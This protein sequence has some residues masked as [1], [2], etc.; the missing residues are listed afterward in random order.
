MPFL[1][2]LLLAGG[3]VG[4]GTALAAESSSLLYCCVEAN[5]QKACGDTLPQACLG[6]GH[7]VIDSRGI[8]VREVSPPLSAEQRAALAEEKRLQ[9]EQAARQKEQARRD[10]VILI[11]YGSEQEIDQMRERAEGE[12]QHAIRD[13]ERK[14][15]ETEQA[16]KDLNEQL[17]ADPND[18]DKDAPSSQDIN[19]KIRDLQA[20]YKLNQELL[21]AKRKELAS[22]RVQ[23]DDTKVRYREARSRADR[24]ASSSTASSGNGK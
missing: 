24:S 21:A 13:L 4:M 8:V 11:T 12:I 15:K 20:E 17:N 16:L 7:Q 14:V 19:R 6:R 23:Y 5:G 3:G 10:R 22:V 9:A 18:A 1:S 2:L